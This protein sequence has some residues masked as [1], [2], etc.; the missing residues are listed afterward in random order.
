MSPDHCVFLFS[1][2]FIGFPQRTILIIKLLFNLRVTL[3]FSFLNQ[4]FSTCLDTRQLLNHSVLKSSK[5]VKSLAPL[6][7]KVPLEQI[8][9][10]F[11]CSI[12]GTCIFLNLVWAKII[13]ILSYYSTKLS[14]FKD[15]KIR[16]LLFYQKQT[17]H[18]I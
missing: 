18:C 5:I 10:I 17:K 16:S 9:Q 13:E 3:T 8:W 15:I 1:N 4:F 7:E 6:L 2:C 12:F 11:K 14:V